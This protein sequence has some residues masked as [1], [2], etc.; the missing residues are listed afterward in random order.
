MTWWGIGAVAVGAGLCGLLVGF[1]ALAWFAAFDD[2]DRL[3]RAAASKVP[4]GQEPP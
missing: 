4:S 3:E 2:L 1:V